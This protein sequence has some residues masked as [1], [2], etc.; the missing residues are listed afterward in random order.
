MKEHPQGSSTWPPLSK[1]RLTAWS[2]LKTPKGREQAGKLIVEGVRS[3]GDAINSG[4]SIEALIAREPDGITVAER[5]PGCDRLAR[6]AATSHDFERIAD[7]VHSSGVAAIVGWKPYPVEALEA[8]RPSRVLYCDAIA[9]PGNLGTLIRTAAGLGLDLVVIGQKSVDVTN[10]KVV[11]ATAGALFRVP[12]YAG[13]TPSQF[14]SWCRERGLTIILADATGG[15]E[16]PVGLKRWGAVIGGETS[17]L[18]RDWPADGAQRVRIRMH[19]GV[20]SLNA[21]VAGAILLDRLSRSETKQ[22]RV[23]SVD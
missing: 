1:R 2:K 10:A 3:V 20:E 15:G 22:P 4:V 9:D 19:K 23:E 13:G 14:V 8:A 11:R 7:T 5:I 12:I 6:F 17:G 18:N 21:S 16:I